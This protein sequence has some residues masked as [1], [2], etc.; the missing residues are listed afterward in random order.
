MPLSKLHLFL[1]RINIRMYR[2]MQTE[3]TNLRQEM[4]RRHTLSFKGSRSHTQTDN[5]FSGMQQPEVDARQQQL[6]QQASE[7][8]H[9]Q[10]EVARLRQERD[11]ARLQI[12]GIAS[13]QAV[14]RKSGGA[15]ASSPS[16]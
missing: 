1:H 14:N 6:E 10:Q 3:L 11:T 5:V 16:L 4:F 7:V 8:Q 12:S 2:R 15:P 13:K 9:L